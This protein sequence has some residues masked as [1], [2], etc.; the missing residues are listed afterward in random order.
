MTHARYAVILTH[1]RPNLLLRCVKAISFQVDMTVIIDNAS[2][3]PVIAT[4]FRPYPS[5]VIRDSE[6]PPN[7]S[8]LWNIGITCVENWTRMQQQESWDLAILCDDAIVHDGWF[9]R[10][11]ACMREHECMAASTHSVLATEYPVLK[12]APDH[13]VYNRMCPWAFILRGEAGIR[14]DEDLRWWWGD[15]HV[16]FTARKLGGMIIAPGPV[17]PNEKMGEFTNIYAHLGEQ[18]GRDGETF[19]AKWGGRPW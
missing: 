16:D 9:Q 6:Q 10:T 19:A 7:L 14:A 5:M 12:T 4:D 8:R 18:A 17:V 3:P 15:T 2:A 1:N 11:A 13:D